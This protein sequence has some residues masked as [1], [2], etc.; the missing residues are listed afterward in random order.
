[1]VR[2][3]ID[4]ALIIKE[5]LNARNVV[6]SITG[7]AAGQPEAIM[8]Q[9]KLAE[10]DSEAGRIFWGITSPT[11]LVP[12]VLDLVAA[13]TGEPTYVLFFRG[14]TPTLD[15]GEAKWAKFYS[16]A[17]SRP[18]Y[19]TSREWLPMPNG[20]CAKNVRDRRSTALILG[21]YTV[22]SSPV[23]IDFSQYTFFNP[24]H[25]NIK[26]GPRQK[27]PSLTHRGRSTVCA[28]KGSHRALPSPH[29]LVGIA[30]LTGERSVWVRA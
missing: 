5:A 7:P 1:M 23:N 28:K 24:G 30:W 20:V 15:G 9:R 3:N 10:L 11:C 16:T 21:Y 2:P 18:S 14:G 29:Q 17:R 19:D 26:P 12:D 8:R 25:L 22:V 13:N 6:I 27:V 4:E